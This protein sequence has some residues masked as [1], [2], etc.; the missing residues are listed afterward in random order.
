[1]KKCRHDWQTPHAIVGG[2][3]SNP[4]VWSL[5]GLRYAF[6]EACV[7]CGCGKHTHHDGESGEETVTYR[8][9]EF[10]AALDGDRS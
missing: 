7:K 9:G 6:T 8:R 5:G 1:M 2:C 3:D 4:G 10:A